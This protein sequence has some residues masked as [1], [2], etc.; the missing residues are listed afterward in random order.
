MFRRYI[1]KIKQAGTLHQHFIVTDT[2]HGNQ[3]VGVHHHEAKATEHME[4]LNSLETS[5]PGI[6]NLLEPEA[7]SS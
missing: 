5:G 4:F 7:E 2:H 3:T 6:W 1:V